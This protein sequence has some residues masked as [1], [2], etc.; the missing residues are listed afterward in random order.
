MHPQ[1]TQDTTARWVVGQE[2][3]LREGRRRDDRAA[4]IKRVGRQY[5]YIEMYGREVA[6]HADDGHQ[7]TDANYAARIFTPASLAAHDRR[8]AASARVQIL[9]QEW[10]WTN[11]IATETLEQIAALIEAN[12]EVTP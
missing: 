5:V 10:G 1:T 9:T 8:A 6:F 4:T 11:R 3:V 2:V 7:K 12:R